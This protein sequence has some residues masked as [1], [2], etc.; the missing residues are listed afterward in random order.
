M[1]RTAG[2]ESSPSEQELAGRLDIPALDRFV[3][4]ADSDASTAAFNFGQLSKP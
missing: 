3:Q 1:Q 4:F 2:I